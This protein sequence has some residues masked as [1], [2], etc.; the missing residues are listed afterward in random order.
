[1]LDFPLTVYYAFKQEDE[2]SG[3]AEDE[4]AS[5]VDLTTGWETL[6]EALVSSGFQITATWPV[7]ASQKW[8]M[9]AM[10]SNALASYIVLA[11]RPRPDARAADIEYP[12]P[13]GIE[14]GSATSPSPFTTRKHSA[15]GLCPGGSRT[16]HGHLFT[17]QLNFG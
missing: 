13:P 16:G 6:L 2:E 12:V 7:R 3:V 9:R 14:I 17:L 4:S 10:G 8:R 15:S 11:C 1:M 5:A